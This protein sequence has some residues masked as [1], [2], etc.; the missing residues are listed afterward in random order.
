LLL[1][2]PGHWRRLVG[3]EMV[4]G[5]HNRQPA[6]DPVVRWGFGVGLVDPVAPLL[7]RPDRWARDLPPHARRLL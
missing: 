1:V 3:R 7:W 5:L 6:V 2:S 4:E